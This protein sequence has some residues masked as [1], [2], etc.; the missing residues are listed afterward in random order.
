MFQTRVIHS[1][2]PTVSGMHR[3][4]R[5][6]EATKP[7]RKKNI[8]NI[9]SSWL[10]GGESPKLAHRYVRYVRLGKHCLVFTEMQLFVM[11]ELN[12]SLRK[13]YYTD[14]LSTSGMACEYCRVTATLTYLVQGFSRLYCSLLF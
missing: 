13:Y 4:T 2:K 10:L 12:S 3:Q 14:G 9:A 7:S 8:E 5:G 6:P 1:R 11:M